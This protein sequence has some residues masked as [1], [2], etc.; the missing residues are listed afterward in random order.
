MRSLRKPDAAAQ[1]RVGCRVIKCP[2]AL[3]Q[4]VLQSLATIAKPWF[5]IMV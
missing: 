5:A 1:T 3:W 2:Q 4:P